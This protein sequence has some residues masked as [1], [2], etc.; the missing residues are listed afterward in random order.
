MW[1]PLTL[2]DDTGETSKFLAP[3]HIINTDIP[4]LLGRDTQEYLNIRIEPATSSCK[5]GHDQNNKVYTLINT[6]SGHWALSLCR[7]QDHILK[8]G[9]TCYARCYAHCSWDMHGEPNGIVWKN[10]KVL[11]ANDDGTYLIKYINYNTIY[12]V[13]REDIA[14]KES[15]IPILKNEHIDELIYAMNNDIEDIAD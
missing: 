4:L 9:T 1:L 8:P 12:N 6:A 14:M 15:E 10:A 7:P 2:Y 11:E 3:V 5:I 13:L